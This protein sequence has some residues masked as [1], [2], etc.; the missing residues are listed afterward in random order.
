M[1][2]VIIHLDPWLMTLLWFFWVTYMFKRY[3]E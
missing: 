1:E 3:H 2:E